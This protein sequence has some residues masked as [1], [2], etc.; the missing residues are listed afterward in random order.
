MDQT[1]PTETQG[2]RPQRNK[3]ICIKAVEQHNP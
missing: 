2:L 1:P 3:P